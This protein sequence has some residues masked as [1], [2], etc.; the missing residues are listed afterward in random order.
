MSLSLSLKNFGPVINGKIIVKP[1]TVF[2]GPN[3]SSKSYTAMALYAFYSGLTRSYAL[4][5]LACAEYSRK[6]KWEEYLQWLQKRAVNVVEKEFRRV[7]G[8]NLQDLTTRGASG[9]ELIL[10]VKHRRE[11]VKYILKW[12]DVSLKIEGLKCSKRGGNNVSA[13]FDYLRSRVLY[14]PAS[15]SGLVQTYGFYVDLVIRVAEELPITGVRLVSLPGIVGDFLRWLLAPPMEE[16][17]LYQLFREKLGVDVERKERGVVVRFDGLEM[18]IRNSPSGIAELAPLG[19]ML[20]HGIVK[21][22]YM[23]IIEEPEAHL[24]PEMQVK[25]MDLLAELAARGV[26]LILTTHSDLMLNRL[27]NIVLEG[28]ILTR[29]KVAVYL[30]K[31][32]GNGYITERIKIGKEGIPDDE[33]LRVYD[34][35][36]K[37][38]MSLIYASQVRESG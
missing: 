6:K 14:L 36:Y 31:R 27:S 38:Y 37:E 12:P 32:E 21:K 19:L 4:P 15:R 23:I 34:Q 29:N 35:L 2:I 13:L 22:K 10:T 8:L 7:F 26:R 18:D 9:G 16:T 5:R 24:H 1:M 33:F 25:T 28:K 3:A 30:F 11:R 17:Q 20:R